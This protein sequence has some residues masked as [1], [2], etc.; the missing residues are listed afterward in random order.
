V[1]KLISAALIVATI[2]AILYIENS[3]PRTYEASGK[4]QM[5]PE[6]TQIS[7][8][9]NTD[10]IRIA[11][12]K[13]RVVLVDFWTYT[14]INCIRTLPYITDWDRKYRGKGLVIIGVHTPEF[15]FEKDYNNVLNAVHKYNIKYPV[16]QDNDYATWKAFNNHYWPAKYL[17][18]K[19]GKI[20]YNHFG[21][22]AY[23]E[24]EKKIQE[25]LSEIG[26]VS[27]TGLSYFKPEAG[28]GLPQTPELY[29]GYSLARQ[30]LGN[31]EG[32]KPGITVDYKL[33]DSLK[34]NLIYLEGKW[35]NNADNLGHSG[36]K[37][38]SINLKFTA[39]TV[40]IVAFPAGSNAEADILVNGRYL[41]KKVA[42]KDIKFE[43]ERSFIAVDHSDLYNLLGM[44]NDYGTYTLKIIVKSDSFAWNAFTFGS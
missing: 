44:D 26:E 28:Y 32:Y 7:G 43:G 22:G 6:L 21:E 20:V 9:I 16:A 33:P 35:Q 36:S 23:E 37:A 10:P 19:D 14:C 12:L 42:G 3:K 13:G 24:T 41:T 34:N 2:I 38:G 40:N 18:N 29:A 5:S 4:G 39:R 17:I 25:L 8:W 27:E 31:E 1:K 15:E 30:Q 11:D